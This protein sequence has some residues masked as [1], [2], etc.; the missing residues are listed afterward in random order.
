M[1]QEEKLLRQ[2][3][4]RWR[5]LRLRDIAD[6]LEELRDDLRAAEEGLDIAWCNQGAVAEDVIEHLWEKLNHSTTTLDL[7]ERSH[8]HLLQMEL[9]E[10]VIYFQRNGED[11]E[12]RAVE[13]RSPSQVLE[14]QAPA[15]GDRATNDEAG[16]SGDAYQSIAEEIARAWQSILGMDVDPER[17]KGHLRALDLWRRRWRSNGRGHEGD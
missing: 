5:D 13:Q 4:Y 9:P 16:A 7:L 17:V 15:P 14:D 12:P 10:L 6:K 11:T 1:D 2:G 3:L 8:A